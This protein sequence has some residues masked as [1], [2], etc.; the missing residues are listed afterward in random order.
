MYTVTAQVYLKD[1]TNP[2]TR[3]F[4]PLLLW[5]PVTLLLLYLVTVVQKPVFIILPMISFLSIIP[6]FIISIKKGK[7]YR[8]YLQENQ[9]VI[10]FNVDVRNHVLYKDKLQLDVQEDPE[11]GVI[12]L[13]HLDHNSGKGTMPTFFATVTKEDSPDLKAFLL[14]NGVEIYPAEE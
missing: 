9:K 2:G 14:E 10:S 1:E 4:I 11:E 3:I 13:M 5:L 8:K 12:Y 6:I 7:A